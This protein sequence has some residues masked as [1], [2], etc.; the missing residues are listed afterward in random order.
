MIGSKFSLTTLAE[1]ASP[2][3]HKLPTKYSNSFI[4]IM[5]LK[6]KP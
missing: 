3:T 5:G 1:P 4:K 6:L 2:F